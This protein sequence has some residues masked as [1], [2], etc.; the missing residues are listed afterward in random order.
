MGE[1][2]LSLAPMIMWVRLLCPLPLMIMLGHW[3]MR[4]FVGGTQTLTF[5]RLHNTLV[6][7]DNGKDN[8]LIFLKFFG[9]N[10]FLTPERSR[11]STFLTPERL[12]AHVLPRL[13]VVDGFSLVPS[14]PS[15]MSPP[16]SS[17]KQKLRNLLIKSLLQTQ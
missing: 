11:H 5:E 7:R 14:S 6:L 3:W 12:W 10:N 16:S 2:A 15:S 17:C 9:P 1:T 4:I 8:T 13:P